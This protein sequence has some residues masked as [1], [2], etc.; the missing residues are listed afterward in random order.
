L[1]TALSTWDE[2]EIA[3]DGGDADQEK[4]ALLVTELFTRSYYN[5]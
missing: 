5:R 1:S 3:L 4:V 2:K